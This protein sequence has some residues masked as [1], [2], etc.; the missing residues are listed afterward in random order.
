MANTALFI[1]NILNAC[2][3]VHEIETELKKPINFLNLPAKRRLKKNKE[4]IIENINYIKTITFTSGWVDDLIL[5]LYANKFRIR[6]LLKEYCITLEVSENNNIPW[7][8]SYLDSTDIVSV[9]VSNSNIIMHIQ[10]PNGSK[11]TITAADN[12][13]KEQNKYFDTLR[14]KINDLLIEYLNKK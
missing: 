3:S 10:N 5:S 1:T 12:E 14:S 13:N 7:S 9:S 11:S 4:K 8:V 2:D 6:D